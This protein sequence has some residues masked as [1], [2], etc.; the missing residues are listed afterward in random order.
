M[1]THAIST[2]RTGQLLMTASADPCLLSIGEAAV[3][4]RTRQLSPVDLI[5]AQLSRIASLDPVLHAFVT[6]T[7]D[8]AR[9]QARVAES[10][11]ASGNYRGPLHGIPIGLKDSI[12][13]AGILTT[14]A[15]V[16]R[17]DHIPEENATVVDKL[18][19]AGAIIVGK[20]NMTE[21]ALYGYHPD[22]D[23]P[24]NPWNTDFYAGVSSSGSAVAVAASMC[25]ASLGSDAGGSIRFPSAACGVVG[26]KPTFGRVSRHGAFPLAQTLD[27][28]GPFARTVQGAATVLNAMSG[29]DP[30]DRSTLQSQLTNDIASP[31]PDGPTLR[32]GLDL[33]YSTTDTDPLIVAALED[34]IEVF[35]STG[36]KIVDVDL[37]GLDD[38]CRYWMTT[39]GVDARIHHEA[40]YPSRRDEYGPVFRSLLDHA[41]HVDATEYAKGE[42]LRQTASAIL[43]RALQRAD[44]LILPGSPSLPLARSAVGP[45]DVFPIEG[46]VPFFRHTVPMNYSGH[47]T[48][49]LPNGFTL[50]GLPIGLQLIGR[51]KEEAR[52]IEAARRF[53]SATEWHLAL[54]SGWQAEFPS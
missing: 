29:F 47:P 7:A 38:V 52:I 24:R 1:G 46:M 45:S 43:D 40:T 16:M 18:T 13:T 39:C 23:H 41:T 42:A 5:E 8:L 32:I 15:S 36:A 10:E 17:H 25:F 54:P 4:I 3:L 28:I 20:L 2:S 11:I 27:H 31:T 44:V 34:S 49:S 30:L 35:R 51:H 50:S 22:L 33:Q 48:I 21:F 37:S 26:I 53:E 12:A 6:V 9:T 19:A 14:C